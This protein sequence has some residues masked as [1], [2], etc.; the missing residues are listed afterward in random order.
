MSK[1]ARAIG[2]GSKI[3]N[4]GN[5]WTRVEYLIFEL[6]DEDIRANLDAMAKLDL[7]FLVRTLHDVATGL[8][9]LHQAQ[10]AHQDL[11]PSNVLVYKREATSKICDLGRAW[12]MN[13]AGPHDNEAI[14]GDRQYAPIEQLYGEKSTDHRVRRFGCDM[15]HLGSLAVFLFGKTHMNSLLIDKLAPQHRPGFWGSGYCA[16]LPFVQAAFD[17]SLE[18]FAQSVPELARNDL[19]VAVSQLCEPDPV[20]RGHPLNRRTRQFSFER[21]ISLFDRLAR[22]AELRLLMKTA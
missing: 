7:A 2:S 19:R 5:P 9:Q 8:A 16:V 15:Y 20:R 21:Y 12:D 14:A 11:K 13:A 22:K 3:L 4:P 1:V 10:I 6:A 18:E 17:L